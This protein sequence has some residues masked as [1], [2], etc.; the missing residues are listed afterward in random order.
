VNPLT[1][2]QPGASNP[3]DR[4][5]AA[6]LLRRAG[7]C[8]S[9]A[10]AQDALREGVEATV[11]R[12]LDDTRDSPSHD[13]LDAMGS[14]IAL[15]GDI[16]RLRGWWALRMARTTRPLHARMAVLW[17]NHFATSN[18]KVQS[19]ALMLQQLRAIERHALGRFEDLLLAMSQ[20]AAMI[21]WLD[22]I[23]NVKGRPNENY[24]REL[25][26]LFSLGVGNYT[27][28]DI[29]EAARAFTGWHQKGGRFHFSRLDHDEGDKTVFGS[30]GN[31]DGADVVRFCVEHESCARFIATRLLR[32]FVCP[33]PP[34]ELTG[35]V[36]TSLRETGFDLRESLRT[37]LSS[38]AFFD[39][40]W[41][42]CRIKSPVEFAVGAVRSL[43]LHAPAARLADAISNMGQS[44]LEPPSVK[45]W[46]GHRAWLNSAT[47]MVRLNAA[48]AITNGGEG[49]VRPADLRATYNLRN[50]DDIRRYCL[51]VTLDGQCPPPL[52]ERIDAITG[53]DDQVFRETMRTLL[54]SPEY[55]MC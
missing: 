21:V 24:A 44:L 15:A 1:P 7:F 26:E 43:E 42:R 47:M 25:F 39:P 40:R 37:L 45:G 36:A 34:A 46:D 54:T 52:R 4:S 13:D 38:E 35:A 29:Q 22:G 10:E 23:Q 18:V 48:T 19:P 51:D 14:K 32:E 2:Y 16:H 30:A 8:P 28:K 3:W 53:G 50:A 11:E 27:E 41:R 55:Q 20:D 5:A 49:G 6:H 12:L 33:D 31:W 9:E 17:H